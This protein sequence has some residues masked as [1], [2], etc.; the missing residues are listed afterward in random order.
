MKWILTISAWLAAT[1][2]LAL[3]CFFAVMALAGPHGG[4]LPEWLHRPAL[5]VAWVLLLS[6]PVWVARLVYQQVVRRG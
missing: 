4:L 3:V 5:L 1:A 2:V 6:V